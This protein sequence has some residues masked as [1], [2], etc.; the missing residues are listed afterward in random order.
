MQSSQNKS[1]GGLVKNPTYNELI[2]YIET[3]ND[4]IKMPD[5]RAKLAAGRHTVIPISSI[6]SPKPLRG[7]HLQKLYG[8]ISSIYPPWHPTPVTCPKL[9]SLH[10]VTCNPP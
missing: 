7:S 1:C 6:S 2:N 10:F 9:G 8:A 3:N 4:K 5:R